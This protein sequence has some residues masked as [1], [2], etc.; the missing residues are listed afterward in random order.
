MEKVHCIKVII[1]IVEILKMIILMVSLN[2]KDKMEKLMMVNGNKVR[3]MV[4][5]YILGLMEVAMKDSILMVKD[6]VKER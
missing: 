1:S 6:K 2:I 4:L 5:V 3:N